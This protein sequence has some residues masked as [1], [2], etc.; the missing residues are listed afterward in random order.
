VLNG[1]HSGLDHFEGRIQRVEIGVQLAGT[2]PVNDPGLQIHIWRAK[3]QWGQADVMVCVDKARENDRV[4]GAEHFHIRGTG[5][6]QLFIRADRLDDAIS[7]GYGT[8]I[9]HEWRSMLVDP[10]DNV[11]SPDER[12]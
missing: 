2:D 12:R 3:L 1:R 10:K 8:I 6:S 5:S 9:Q 4:S 11:G 7:L